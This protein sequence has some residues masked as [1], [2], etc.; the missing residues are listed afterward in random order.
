MTVTP[1]FKGNTQPTKVDLHAK[2]EIFLE[3]MD[4]YSSDFSGYIIVTGLRRINVLVTVTEFS[5]S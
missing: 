2:I 1:I 3:L 4:G 5:R